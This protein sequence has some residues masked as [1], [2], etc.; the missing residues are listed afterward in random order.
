VSS[1]LTSS[2]ND[3]KKLALKTDQKAIRLSTKASFLSPRGETP[4]NASMH[5]SVKNMGAM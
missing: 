1:P 3:K 2:E 4:G 5:V